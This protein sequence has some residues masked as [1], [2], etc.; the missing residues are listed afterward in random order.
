ML[1]INKTLS[2]LGVGAIIVIFIVIF[3]GVNDRV[4]KSGNWATFT[5]L[6][7]VVFQSVG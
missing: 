3:F 7:W 1:K 6:L 2:S 4:A 5:L